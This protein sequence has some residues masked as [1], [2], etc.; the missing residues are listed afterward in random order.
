MAMCVPPCEAAR[1]APLLFPTSFLPTSIHEL[2]LGQKCKSLMVPDSQ[3]MLGEK[4]KKEKAK[5]DF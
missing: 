4:K 3:M 1:L 5:A 2:L